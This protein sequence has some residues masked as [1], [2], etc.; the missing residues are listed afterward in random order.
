MDVCILSHSPAAY[1][2]DAPGTEA[3]ALRNGT[4]HARPRRTDRQTDRR[5]DEHHG[6]SATFRSDERTLA[7]SRAEKS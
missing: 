5:T 4:M 1:L 7:H 2:I 6:N 3:L